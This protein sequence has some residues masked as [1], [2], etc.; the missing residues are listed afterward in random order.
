MR[1]HQSS[2]T[3]TSLRPAAPVPVL[4]PALA[5]CAG[6]RLLPRCESRAEGVR[7]VANA[8][9]GLW[10]RDGRPPR[11]VELWRAGGLEEGQDLAFPIGVA[12]SRDGRIA[13]PDWVLGE[14][15]VVDADGEWLGAWTRK[16]RGPGETLRPAAAAWTAEGHLA[17][18][19]IENSKVVFRSAEGAVAPD[20]PVHHALTAPVLLSGELEWVGVDARGAVALAPGARPD[21]QA[22]ELF[23]TSL[24]S[25]PPGRDEPDTLAIAPIPVV[26]EGRYEGWALPGVPRVVGA[27][28]ADGRIAVGGEDA[29]SSITVLD[30]T[31][32]PLLRICREAPPLP[33][34]AAERL[35]TGVPERMEELAVALRNAPR[36]EQPA[37]YARLFFSADGWLW[38]RRDRSDPFA[39]G[40]LHGPRGAR[41]DVFD[42]DGRYLGEA[43]AP[44][45]QCWL[46]QRVTACGRSRPVGSMRRRWSPTGSSWSE[47]QHGPRGGGA[48][49]RPGPLR[50]V[51]PAR[52]LREL[53]GRRPGRRMLARES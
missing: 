37:P 16:G 11:L 8:G 49:R 47:A 40:Q 30:T 26:G 13:I 18:F 4:L 52:R 45:G 44:P 43:Q 53:R 14:V 2:C 3:A 23:F 39:V 5:A 19:D 15:A 28:A 38:V 48:F 36:P 21:P 7:T 22:P 20:S 27:L 25:L 24:L 17:V 1:R 29:S 46:P 50:G 10:E 42:A 51:A 32:A 34:T 35:E 12:A 9:P 31:G 33:L 41:S 6:D